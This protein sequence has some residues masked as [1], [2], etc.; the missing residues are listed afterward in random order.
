MKLVVIDAEK[1]STVKLLLSLAREMGLKASVQ[2]KKSKELKLYPMPDDDDLL[3]KMLNES[4]ENFSKGNYVTGT[5]AR[6]QVE[7]WRKKKK[8]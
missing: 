4:E 1:D 7:K 3:D 8:K 5:Q 2:T 6:Q